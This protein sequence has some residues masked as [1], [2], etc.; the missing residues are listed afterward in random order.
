MGILDKLKGL[1]GGNADKVEDGIDKAAEVIKDKVP[2]EHDD[3]VDMAVDKAKD[4]VDG[5]DE[6]E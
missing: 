3:K 2:D 4:V 6:E 1:I 5:L